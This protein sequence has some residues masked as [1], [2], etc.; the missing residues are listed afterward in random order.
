MLVLCINWEENYPEYAYSPGA[1]FSVINYTFF[2]ML[3]R[4][5]H[6]HVCLWGGKEL[7]VAGRI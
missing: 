3:K 2:V 5:W 7:F 4:T 1:V 6:P